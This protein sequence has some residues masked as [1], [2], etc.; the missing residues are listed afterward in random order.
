MRS[1]GLNP[2]QP[3]ELTWPPFQLSYYIVLGKNGVKMIVIPGSFGLNVYFH[4]LCNGLL[5][6][7]RDDDISTCPWNMHGTR[8]H[9]MDSLI[10]WISVSKVISSHC[11]PTGSVGHRFVPERAWK[12]MRTTSFPFL[13][14]YCHCNCL[15]PFLIPLIFI[16]FVAT[17]CR[18]LLI[19]ALHVLCI[20]AFVCLFIIC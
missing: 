13:W 19:T 11:W 7:C 20:W 10:T 9:G 18:C 8:L 3:A 4:Y 5:Y 6:W 14:M 2:E 17:L 12:H 15:G 1:H 16:Q